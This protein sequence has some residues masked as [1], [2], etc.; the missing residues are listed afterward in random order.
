[1]FGSGDFALFLKLDFQLANVN[2][3]WSLYKAQNYFK[4]STNRCQYFSV[5]E[6]FTQLEVQTASVKLT[7]TYSQLSDIYSHSEGV[8]INLYTIYECGPR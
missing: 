2:I 4:Y 3:L 6:L 5:I 8:H 1:M 7:L